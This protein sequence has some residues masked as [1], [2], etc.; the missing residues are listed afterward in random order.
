MAVLHLHHMDL[1]RR[2]TE[3]CEQ[4][5]EAVLRCHHQ[6]MREE[7][8]VIV[9]TTQIMGIQAGGGTANWVVDMA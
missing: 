7:D 3:V 1:Y 2:T 4:I 9:E 5:L 6:R 8:M